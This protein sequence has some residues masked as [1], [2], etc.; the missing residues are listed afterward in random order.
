[1]EEFLKIL[2]APLT[3]CFKSRSFASKV[4]LLLQKS[5][6][7]DE[8]SVKLKTKQTLSS[9]LELAF[10]SGFTPPPPR[11]APVE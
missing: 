1:M 4:V 7:T 5:L 2:Q 3:F 6:K 11:S 10:D 9:V 8:L